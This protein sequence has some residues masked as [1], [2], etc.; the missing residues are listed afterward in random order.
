MNGVLN[1]LL[2]VLSLTHVHSI[3]YI[4]HKNGRL[5]GVVVVVFSL[6]FIK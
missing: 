4:Q 5:Y 1:Y 3:P 2:L 6:K